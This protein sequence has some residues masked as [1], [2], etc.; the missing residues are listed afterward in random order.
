MLGGI[1]E[2]DLISF[3]TA[4]LS[5]IG[6]GVIVADREGRVLYINESGEALTGMTESQALGRPFEEVFPLVHYYSGARLESPIRATLRL[7]KPQGLQNH[8][9]LRTGGGRPRFV[10]ASCS[11]IVGGDGRT[12]GVVVVFRDIDRIK[13]IEEEIKKEKDNLKTVLEALPAGALLAGA[14][15]LVRWVNRPLLELFRIREEEIVGQRLGG[16]PHCL[17]SC[18]NG[19][20]QGV[21]SPDCEIQKNV[22]AAISDGL[23]RRDVLIRGPF[24]GENPAEPLWL[25]MNFIPLSRSAEPLVLIT[26]EDVTEQKNYEEALRRSRDEEASANRIKSEFIANMSHEI[27]TP[28][29]GLIGMLDLLSAS[30]LDAEQL[31]YIQMAKLSANTLL[32]VIGDILDYSKIEAGKILIQHVS[33][34][35]PALMAET[36]RLHETLAEQK[37]LTLRYSSSPGI[38]RFVMG[39]PDRLRQILGNLIANAIKFTDRGGVCVALEKTP[40]PEGGDFLEFQISDTGIGISAQQMSLLFKR[41]SQADGSITRR[42]SGSGLGLAISKQLAELMGGTLDAQSEPGEG[43]VFTLRLALIPGAG[44]G[45]GARREPS[46]VVLEAAAVRPANDEQNPGERIVIAQS[47]GSPDRGSRVSIGP[48]GEILFEDAPRNKKNPAG[49][50]DALFVQ[51]RALKT[52]AGENRF[53]ALEETA[54]Q[55]RQLALALGAQELADM[56]FRAQLAARGSKWDNAREYAI[57]MINEIHFRYKE[58]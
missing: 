42:H 4:T 8:S 36:V 57:M 32:K 21:P 17:C 47:V 3:L 20:G 38:P 1:Q 10:S 2:S 39:D 31:D 14:D 12:G 56:A 5:C 35:L 26:V 16:A 51:L 27:R 30:R 43:S 33:F 49:D 48:N 15:L 37:G 7:G 9:A 54:H 55:I 22:H 41:F 44:D 13:T 28:L 18:E 19:C 53:S 25:K 52:V 6:D 50:L 58:G 29:N 45:F 46:A 23:L 34:D 24:M 11:P 40:S